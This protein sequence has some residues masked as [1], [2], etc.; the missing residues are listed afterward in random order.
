MKNYDETICTVF[1]RIDE[2]EKAKSHKRKVALKILIPVT[3][4]CLATIIG[5]FVWQTQTVKPN[6]TS[7]SSANSS[8]KSTLNGI[9][10]GPII[11]DT[12]DGSVDSMG[13]TRLNEKRITLTLNDVLRDQNNKNSL[14]AVS[15]GFELDKNFVYNGKSLTEY[16]A[17]ADEERLEFDKLGILL[18]FGDELKYGEDLYKVGTPDGYKW[19]KELYESVVE[20]IGKDLLDKYI[21][22]GEFLKEKLNTDIGSQEQNTPCKTAYETACEAFYQHAIDQAI[23]RLEQQS[24]NYERRV[25][26]IIFVTADDF[27]SVKLENVLFYGLASKE[28]EAADLFV[29]FDDVITD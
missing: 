26:L 24:I 25:G 3:C 29:S 9:P 19:A 18:K 23:K 27:D 5:V 4:V 6:S 20:E 14:I 21:V 16:E 1:K 13:Y 11:W 28:K 22:N 7:N 15:V 10:D 8:D 17:D 12:S 2:F